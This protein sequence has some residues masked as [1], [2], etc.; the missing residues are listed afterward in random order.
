MTHLDAAL[1]RNPPG[2]LDAPFAAASIG[3]LALI[4]I[5]AF[6]QLAVATVM[7]GVAAALN[8]GSLYAAAFGAAAAAAIA[9]MV[10][11]GHWCDRAGPAAPL[12][13]GAAA[14][15]LGLVLA[16]VAPDMALLV[17]GRALQGGGGGL[18]SV[19]LYVVV[20]RHYPSTLH[21]RI[22]AA[23]AGAWVVPAIVGPALAGLIARY[24]GWRWVFLAAALLTVPALL[25]LQRGL[26][27]LT[28]AGSRS[29]PTG[30]VAAPSATPSATPARREIVAAIATAISAVLLYAG[31]QAL[32]L[33]ALLLALVA[34]IGLALFAPRLLPA[35]SLRA[36]RGLP[37]VV[38]LRGLVAANFF[39]AEVFL[40]L[41]LTTERGLSPVQAGLVLTVGALGWSAG[42][43][44]QGREGRAGD[45]A[46]CVRRLRTGLAMMGG[47][48][49]IVTLALLPA[50]STAVAVT[51]AVT[52]WLIAGIGIGLVYPT[53][54]VLA[55]R[56][57]PPQQQGRASSA[58]QLSDSLF[59]AVG[60]AFASAL[61]GAVQ[62]HS[63]RAAFA[64]G[65]ALAATLSLVGVAVVSRARRAG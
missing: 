27:G 14:F 19:A 40:P 35:G 53:L 63:P 48:T 58:L 29:E 25:L 9:G 37:A 56:F 34:L 47:G 20:G 8:G 6:E 33:R 1:N 10:A 65:L 54:S 4:S 16:G 23:F 59:S 45:D 18:M 44:F 42:S 61:L 28:Q 62:P 24:L 43:W 51:V 22:F 57:A 49:L 36:A 52:G 46:A 38:A 12:T 2:L 15:A 7:P 32:D 21:P 30:A 17:V 31:G 13:A 11:A 26:A 39:A 41:L 55:L 3:M 50:L 64:A 60:L 5:L